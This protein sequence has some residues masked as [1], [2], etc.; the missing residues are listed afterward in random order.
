MSMLSKPTPTLTLSFA[1][2]SLGNLIDSI[3]AQTS[4]KRKAP[5]SGHYGLAND[6]SLAV[7]LVSLSRLMQARDDEILHPAAQSPV[8]IAVLDALRAAVLRVAIA[9]GGADPA[10]S[11]MQVTTLFNL[12]ASHVATK[13]LYDGGLSLPSKLPWDRAKALLAALLDSLTSARGAD[14]G[15]RV[16]ERLLHNYQRPHSTPPPKRTL[17]RWSRWWSAT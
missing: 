1:N 14:V 12:S 17:R 13:R 3:D 2:L 8:G 16:G 15:Y 5:C 6:S 7:R 9:V 10:M 4:T 11:A